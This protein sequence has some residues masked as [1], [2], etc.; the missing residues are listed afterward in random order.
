[1]PESGGNHRER[2]DFRSRGA[3]RVRK[4][5]MLEFVPCTERLKECE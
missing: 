3:W 1:M 5:L 2:E 4:L